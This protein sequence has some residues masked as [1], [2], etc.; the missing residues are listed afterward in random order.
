[1]DVENYLTYIKGYNIDVDNVVSRQDSVVGL[2][3]KIL[4]KRL[5]DAKDAFMLL[6]DNNMNTDAM[7][8]AGHI[9]ETC[10]TIHYIKAA[11]D[12]IFNTRRYVAKST[13]SSAYD[14]LGIDNTNLQDEKYKLAMDDFLDYLDDVGHL[15]LKP[16]KKEDRKQ[17]NK[18]LVSKLRSANL[19]NKDKRKL[20]KEY[21]D[22]PIVNDY[23]NCFIS[24]MQNAVKDKPDENAEKLEEAIKL[25]YVSYCRIKHAS[26]LLYPG[27]I[28]A[29]KVIIRDNKEELCIPAVFLSLDMIS[30]TPAYLKHKSATNT[31][32]V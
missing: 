14:L 19:T 26:A 5:H 25:F 1:M 17:L 6:C 15:I 18:K 20:I 32:Q 2:N 16:S 8:I 23:I 9:L 27:E 29:D 30:D 3:L 31:S 24:G 21:Y 10:A 11:K 13:V 4:Y 7:L 22:M 12:K 28:Y